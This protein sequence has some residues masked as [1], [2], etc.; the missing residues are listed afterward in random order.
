MPSGRPRKKLISREQLEG[1]TEPSDAMQTVSDAL[2]VY[3]RPKPIQGAA[4]HTNRIDHPPTP[5]SP[6]L[7]L[8]KAIGNAP[9]MKQNYYKINAHYQFRAVIHFLR[10]QLGY[11]P[12]VPLVCP[13][14]MLQLLRTSL[15]LSVV[16][17][18]T[19]TS[20]FLSRLRPTTLS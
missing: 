3:Q 18:S 19:H 14:I 8:F 11:T 4:Q 16:F 9:I 13:Q 6:A 17:W 12:H 7:I 15:P 10:K 2:Q 5:C 1:P 20:I